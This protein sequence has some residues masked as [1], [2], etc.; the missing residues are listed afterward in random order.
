MEKFG[1]F[2]AVFEPGLHFAGLDLLGCCVQFRSISKRVQQQRCKVSS[3]TKDR[4]F[5]TVHIAVQRSVLP[6]N[7]GE[8]IYSVTDMSKQVEAGVADV[9]RSL[10]PQHTLDEFF[11][12][13]EELAQ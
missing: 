4:L 9:V 8:A 10:V 6:E 5:V 12:L 7:V 11:A 2:E 1:K 3:I 13:A